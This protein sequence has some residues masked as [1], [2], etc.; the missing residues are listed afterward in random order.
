MVASLMTID[1]N[2]VLSAVA[3]ACAAGAALIL[4]SM[5][6]RKPLLDR[7]MKLWL[8]VGLGPLPILAAG[9]GNVANFELTK[10]RHFCAS[11]HVMTP[12]AADAMNPESRTLAAVHSQNPFFGGES[13]YT[14]HADYGMFGTV[15]TKLGGMR[16]VWDFYTGDWDGDPPR[17][18]ELYEPYKISTCEQCHPQVE[19]RMPLAHKLHAAALQDTRVSCVAAG[20]HG[21]P[22][23]RDPAPPAE[24]P[25]AEVVH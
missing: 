22:H 15:T 12:Y 23:P 13:C 1:T 19:A 20:C 11:C 24:A 7:N 8:F 2:S 17:K 18:P 3:L 10:E 9:A 25:H 14:C 5:L 16:H 21:P 4:V 6:I